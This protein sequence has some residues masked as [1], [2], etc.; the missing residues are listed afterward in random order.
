MDPRSQYCSWLI[1]LAE[2]Y[3]VSLSFK[4]LIIPSCKDTFLRIY[5]GS[6]NTAPL[7]GTYCGSNANTELVVLSS[8]NNLYIVSNSGSYERSAKNIFT[9]HAQYN[10]TNSTGWYIHERKFV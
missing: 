2:T 4:E 1:T 3:I 9:F 8:T 10:A 6:N 5:D 7:L